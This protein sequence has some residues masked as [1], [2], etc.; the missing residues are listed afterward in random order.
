MTEAIK[1]ID[2]DVKTVLAE[3]IADYEKRT[4]KILQPAHIE[5]S[6]IQTYAYREQLL[7][8]GINHA[9]YKPF[10]SLRRGLR[11]ICAGKLLVVIGLEINLPVLY[12]A[13]Q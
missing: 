12:Y 10:R 8:K 1:I 5:R 7:R 3:A 6:I 11:W 13:F 2:D 4:G 9:F